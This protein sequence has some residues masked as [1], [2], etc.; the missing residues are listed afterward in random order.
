MLR[1]FKTSDISTLANWVTS[2][3]ELRIFSGDTWT[4]P[5]SEKAIAAYLE[6][7]PE[8]YQFLY[9]EGE[10]TIGFGELILHDTDVPRLS[11]LIVSEKYRGMG[12]GMKMISDLVEKSKRLATLRDIYLFVLEDND[13]A[14]ACYEK[15]GFEYEPDNTFS[16]SYKGQVYPIL[17]MR[18]TLL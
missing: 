4:F 9:H 2:E 14:R 16:M 1:P 10:E 3:E 12:H 8:R 7:Y 17:K 5:L 13:K 6:T 15:C 18:K 11:R